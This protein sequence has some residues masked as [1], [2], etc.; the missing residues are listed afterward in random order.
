MNN[1]LVFFVEG[2]TELEFYKYLIN[3]EKSRSSKKFDTHIK[4]VDVKGIGGF[5]SKALRKFSKEIKTKFSND[6]KFTIVFCSDTDVLDFS[7][8][9]PIDWKKLENDF[10][11]KGANKVINI[12]AKK[13][14]EDWFL[15]DTEGVLKFLK[16]PLKT[17]VSGKNGVE[18]L[19]KLF[20][21]KNKVYYK[22]IKCKELIE[23]LDIEKIVT[24]VKSE[25]IPLYSVLGINKF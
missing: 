22:G 14:I 1:C 11:E 21:K 9:P 4:F 13:T 18:K 2:E 17:R 8:K 15:Y 10:I 24:E 6:C 19:Q 16:L 5:A 7:P 20:L 23:N 12:Q 25:L 3:Y